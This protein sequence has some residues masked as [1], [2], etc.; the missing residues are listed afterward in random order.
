MPR[1]PREPYTCPCCGYTTRQKSHMVHHLFNLVNPCP[2]TMTQVEL[3][4]D[5]K[6]NILTYRVYMPPKQEIPPKRLSKKKISHAL[7][8]V[9][10]NKYIGE[11]VGKSQ[12][13]C[14]KINFITQHNFHCGH[15]LAE[16]NGGT[17]NIDNLRP[18][19]NVCN[20]SMGTINMQEYALDNFNVVI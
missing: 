12:C 13:M 19:C 15:V 1:I 18:I 8:I 14:C 16:A 20:N 10:W 2:R 9:C 17:L 7:R 3:S 6:Q 11:D 4:Q 5:D